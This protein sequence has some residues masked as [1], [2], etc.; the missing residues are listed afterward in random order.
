[1]QKLMTSDRLFVTLKMANWRML[2]LIDLTGRH[3]ILHCWPGE[4]AIG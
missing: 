1:M 2:M 3:I 4:Q